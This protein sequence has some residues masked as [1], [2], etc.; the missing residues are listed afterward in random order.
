[1][2]A[3]QK[4]TTSPPIHFSNVPSLN[5]GLTGLLNRSKI[6]RSVT[7]ENRKTIITVTAIYLAH[8]AVA[9]W[10]DWYVDP[11]LVVQ[12]LSLPFLKLRN[13]FWISGCKFFSIDTT[14]G[15][16]I[17]M[18]DTGVDTLQWCRLCHLWDIQECDHLCARYKHVITHARRLQSTGVQ[19]IACAILG[20]QS[21]AS[22]NMSTKFNFDTLHEQRYY[23]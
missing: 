22:V 20:V 8:F 12:I 21:I 5:T 7:M 4:S 6:D 16:F 23:L 3:W 11:Q 17:H 2:R 19:S 1:M 10:G 15:K 14:K 13:F 9:L 18:L